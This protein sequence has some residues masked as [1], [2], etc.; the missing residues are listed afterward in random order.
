MHKWFF[1]DLNL[2]SI[3]FVK[4]TYIKIYCEFIDMKIVEF[5]FFILIKKK[6]MNQHFFFLKKSEQKLKI[7]K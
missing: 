3:E 5:F 4:L 2:I 7:N 6:C 1:N